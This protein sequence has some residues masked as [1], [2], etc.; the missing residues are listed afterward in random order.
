MSDNEWSG[1]EVFDQRT[2]NILAFPEATSDEAAIR[3]VEMGFRDTTGLVLTH[4][5]DSGA[6]RVVKAWVG[7]MVTP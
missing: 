5:D 1:Y 7:P 4:E 3:V 6:Y 2:K